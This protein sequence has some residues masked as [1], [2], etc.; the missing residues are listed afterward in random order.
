MATGPVLSSWFLLAQQTEPIP[1]SLLGGWLSVAAFTLG[2]LFLI[3][4]VI[5]LYRQLTHVNHSES[6][7]TQAELT[8]LEKSVKAEVT[9]IRSELSQFATKADFE[10]IERTL[11]EAF[12][13]LDD[14]THKQT[15]D[16]RG[17][18]DPIGNRL[19]VLEEKQRGL[20]MQFSR[21]LDSIDKNND[22]L[23]ELTAV[24]RLLTL[25]SAK[26]TV[27]LMPTEGGKRI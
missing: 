5:V 12:R 17:L 24:V 15:H 13:K 9:S 23:A 19:A 21:S 1:F 14:Y 16:L 2:G 7:V 6:V 25:G 8:V 10:K 26:T 18:L 22:R 11:T 4:Q 3:L 27:E 20:E